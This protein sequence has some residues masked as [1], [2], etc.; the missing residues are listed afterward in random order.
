MPFVLIGTWLRAVY[1]YKMLAAGLE[2]KILL[3][4][5]K[6]TYDNWDLFGYSALIAIFWPLIM[7]ILG[8]VYTGKGI[9]K[10]LDKMV[11]QRKILQT[12]TVDILEAEFKELE[13]PI[14]AAKEEKQ[15]WLEDCLG[16]REETNWNAH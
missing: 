2:A 6:D 13:E 14:I 4:K 8:L 7:P 11:A 3:L 12:P 5:S 16:Y 9:G 15:E 1:A 10:S